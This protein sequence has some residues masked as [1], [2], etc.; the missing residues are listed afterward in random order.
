MK[1]I[2]FIISINLILISSIY[3]QFTLQWTDLYQG[4]YGKSL[5]IDGAGNSYVTGWG[6]GLGYNTMKY[7]SS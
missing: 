3:S 2:I 5:A 1:K 4:A 6:W 7:N